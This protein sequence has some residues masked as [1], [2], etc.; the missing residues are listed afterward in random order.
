[1]TA[2]DLRLECLKLTYAHGR[3]PAEAV[4]RAKILEQY[5]LMESKVPAQKTLTLPKKPVSR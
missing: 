4:E 3:E 1:M 2:A 5:L